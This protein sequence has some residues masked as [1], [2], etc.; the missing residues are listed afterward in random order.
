MKFVRKIYEN[1]KIKNYKIKIDREKNMKEN[2]EKRKEI[3]EVNLYKYNRVYFYDRRIQKKL[4][5]E[6]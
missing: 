1:R 5:N 4:Q 3:D 2:K 6:K